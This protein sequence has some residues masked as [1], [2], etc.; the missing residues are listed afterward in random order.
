MK[1]NLFNRLSL[2]ILSSLFFSVI[3]I[4]ISEKIRFSHIN[5]AP[6]GG[7]SWAVWA[8]PLLISVGIVL[9]SIIFKVG[10]WIKL[11]L[12]SLVILFAVFFVLTG[13]LLFSNFLPFGIY[14]VSV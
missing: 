3:L 10:N 9:S 5:L 8:Y 12:I 4:V 14:A 7:Y 11:F 1:L 6:F 13:G 2:F